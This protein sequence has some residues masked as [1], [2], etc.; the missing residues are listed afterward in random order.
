MLVTVK[1]DIFFHARLLS[2]SKNPFHR[3]RTL[4]AGV[5]LSYFHST[6]S[7]EKRPDT[8]I[9]ALFHE[10][11][12][13]LFNARGALGVGVAGRSRWENPSG[14]L[15]RHRAGRS[16]PA[17]RKRRGR[18]PGR[19]RRGVERSGRASHI[20]YLQNHLGRKREL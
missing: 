3:Q 7:P 6:R 9:M 13:T 4:T 18:A 15:A 17:T 5:A 20:D 16:G 14:F 1:G 2:P 10:Q 8:A 11:A 19:E 12:D